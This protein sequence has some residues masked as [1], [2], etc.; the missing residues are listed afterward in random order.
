[1]KNT[2]VPTPATQFAEWYL[3]RDG[4]GL[5]AAEYWN[6]PGRAWTTTPTYNAIPS[7][8]PSGEAVADAIPCNAAGATSD[9]TYYVGVGRFSSNLTSVTFH[10]AVVDV[11]HG[12]PGAGN[13]YGARTPLVTLDA[14]IAREPDVHRL[15]NSLAAELWSYVRGVAVVEAQPFWRAAVLPD[16][17]VKPLV[18]AYHAAGTWDA[19]QFVSE[20]SGD[21]LI[22]FERAVSGQATFQLDCPIA[23]IDLTRA[24]VLRA[25]AR[26]L[27]ADGWSE[28][29]P[30]SVEVGYA[31]FLEA[32]G[33]LVGS[34]SVVGRL[35]YEGAMVS[36]DYVAIG[37]DHLGR[38]ADA[39][40]RMVE[41]RRN[42]ISGLEAVWRL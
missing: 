4:G 37:N 32:D 41:V 2:S 36:R 38:F 21:D 5:P 25:W 28:F 35:A 17:T 33:S 30:W 6:E 7:D 12:G 31:V 40:V 29:G 3:K 14:T 26:W 9:P 1:V 18:H 24:H 20:S 39:Y 16:A 8:E 23:G 10:G 11:Q 19:L 34:G 42:P 13:S 27:G 22:R 15:P